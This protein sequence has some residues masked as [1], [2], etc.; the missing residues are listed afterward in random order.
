ML[1]LSLQT[2]L[3]AGSV[4]AEIACSPLIYFTTAPHSLPPPRSL[5]LDAFKCSI[6]EQVRLV[7]GRRSKSDLLGVQLRWC[8]GKPVA[9]A[10]RAIHTT[11]ERFENNV[12]FFYILKKLCIH[13]T[14]FENSS[15][16]TRILIPQVIAYN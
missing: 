8:Q 12:F 9:A 1:I 10:S 6:I 14:P 11:T 5:H 2:L 3:L 13:T 7:S 15:P 4:L 16:S